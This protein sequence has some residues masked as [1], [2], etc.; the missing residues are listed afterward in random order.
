MFSTAQVVHD[1]TRGSVIK[2]QPNILLV[3]QEC[4]VWAHAAGLIVGTFIKYFITLKKMLII[5]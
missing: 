3:K 4:P 5:T 1:I 2:A